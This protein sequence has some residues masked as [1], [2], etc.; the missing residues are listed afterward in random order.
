[1]ITRMRYALADLPEEH[2]RVEEIVR[3]LAWGRT[4]PH[5]I[6]TEESHFDET[7]LRTARSAQ[8]ASMIPNG[9][10]PDRNP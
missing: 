6:P 1:M 10:A 9:Q 8:M 2:Q 5:A 7:Y 3:R 4:G